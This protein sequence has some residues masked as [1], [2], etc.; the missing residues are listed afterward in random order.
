MF[1]PESQGLLGSF[2]ILHQIGMIL[3][4]YFRFYWRHYDMKCFDGSDVSDWKVVKIVRINAC[5]ILDVLRL[6]PV[7]LSPS[8]PRT[9]C[10]S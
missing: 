4:F 8:N 7:T 2:M 5:K 3:G 10:H 6:M 1:R 9:D